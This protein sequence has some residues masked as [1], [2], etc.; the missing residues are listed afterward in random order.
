V[1]KTLFS[2]LKL[3]LTNSDSFVSVL[4]IQY[5]EFISVYSYGFKKTRIFA[6]GAMR[7]R[8]GSF[9][10]GKSACFAYSTSNFGPG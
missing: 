1:R 4:R 8:V 5:L 6:A 10:P 7:V 2:G 3:E 9:G